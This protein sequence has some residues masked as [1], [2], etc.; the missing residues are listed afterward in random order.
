MKKKI[1]LT[2]FAL[3]ILTIAIITY[4]VLRDISYERK[5]KNEISQITE[6]TKDWQN[7]NKEQF[8]EKINRTI[9]KKD[10]ALVEKSAKKYL[11]DSVNNMLEI[12]N[13][14]ENENIT[15]ILT[16]DNYNNDGPDFTNTKNYLLDTKNKLTTGLDNYYKYLTKD[17]II[18]YLDPSLDKYYKNFYL[19]EL[20]GD[21]EKEFN[22]KTIDTSIKNLLTLLDNSEK[23]IDFLIENKT[24]WYVKDGNIVFKT[25]DLLNTYNTLVDNL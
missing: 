16:A 6:L 13:I 20:I 23:I 10:Y 8:E 5:L 19:N 15:K 14:L 3:L 22:D 1:I 9:T 25:N 24:S 17:V 12:T 2:I 11:K 4:L 7:F 21:Y 18:S